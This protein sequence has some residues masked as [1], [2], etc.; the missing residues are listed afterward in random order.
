[1]RHLFHLILAAGLVCMGCEKKAEEA[2]AE[3]PQAEPAPAQK[4]AQESPA[5]P[6]Q[7][8]QLL[9]RAIAAHGGADKLKAVAA[10][11]AQ[12]EGESPLGS[13]TATS[14]VAHGHHRMDTKLANG[15]QFTFTRGPEHCWAKK[16]PVILPM[17]T[18]EKEPHQA[19]AALMEA[20]FL[21]PVKEKGLALKASKVKIGDSECDQLEIN[22]SSVVT[23]S[24]V[25]DPQSHLLIQAGVN[26]QG[27]VEGRSQEIK[28]A[29]SE[30]KEF[31]GVKMA[32]RQA[33][34]LNGKPM[35]LLMIKEASCDPVEMKVF[36]QPEQVADGTIRERPT[37]PVTIA[38]TTMKGPYTGLEEAM[39]GLME[40]L[41]ENKVPPIGRPL[42]IYKQGPPRVKKPKK[43]V[44]QVCFPVN[45]KAPKKPKKKGKLTIISIKPGKALAAYGIGA[46]AQKAPE[47]AALLVKEAKKRKLKRLGPMIHLT[48]MNPQT[49]PADQLVSELLLPVKAKKQRK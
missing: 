1:M 29:L 24:L 3:Q 19:T 31:C 35:Q 21:W 45:L 32:S 33:S 11:T 2:P 26:V 8:A 13:F 12:V 42:M 18:G 17:G 36:T 44:T 4:T 22:W 5:K 15:N 27:P 41:V 7:A 28:I 23:G 14:T 43:W 10:V 40:A 20:M 37:S 49:T 47:L 38:C 48:Y 25:F 16:G 39:K 30:Y 34:S 6:D 46:Y 9:D